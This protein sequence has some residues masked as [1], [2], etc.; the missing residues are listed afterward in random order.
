[1]ICNQY[2]C[3]FFNSSSR[4]KAW[5]KIDKED[6]LYDRLIKEYEILGVVASLVTATLGMVLDNKNI[7]LGYRFGYNLVNGLG[8]IFSLS[9]IVFCLVI[10]TLLSAVEKK[11]IM[12][13]IK[14]ASYFLSI[15]L[16]CM[17]VGLTSMYICVTMYFGGTLSW[18]LFPFS[19]ILY[20]TG[21][22]F[23]WYLRSKVLIWASDDSEA[24]NDLNI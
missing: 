14:T 21:L 24:E 9:C 3:E 1:M 5:E 6:V 4:L 20:F 17:K 15:P 12:N 7:Y 18:I 11:N 2:N 22:Y 13:F 8:I 10:T 23:Y 19:I 16:I